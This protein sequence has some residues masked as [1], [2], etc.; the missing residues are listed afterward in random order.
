MK[1]PRVS[2]YPVV[3]EIMQQVHQIEEGETWMTAY[4]CYLA[5]GILPLDPAEAWKL[6]IKFKQVHHN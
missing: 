2:R 1:T 4:Q 5:E 6:K 3:G